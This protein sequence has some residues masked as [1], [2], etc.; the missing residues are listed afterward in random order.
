MEE[1]FFQFSNM[2]SSGL[3]ENLKKA[4]S[5][6]G[7]QVYF[8]GGKTIRSHLVATEDKDHIFK[9]VESYTD[10]NVTGWSVMKNI[11]ECL[12]EHLERGSRK[13]KGPSPINGHF[14]TTGHTTTIENF[15]IV[16]REDQT[17]IRTIKEVLYI[18]VNNPSPNKS[19]SKYHLPHK[20]NEVLFNTSEL[21][22]S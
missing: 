21:K 11:L 7:V 8:R 12:L 16:G 18:R 10:T 5:K 20:W 1:N 19:I 14:N 6:H 4:C 3:S 13:S 9:K 15:S 17:L 2:A 22:F